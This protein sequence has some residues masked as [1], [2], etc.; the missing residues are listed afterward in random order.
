MTEELDKDDSCPDCGEK[1][2]DPVVLKNAGGL[3]GWMCLN[4]ETFFP[5]K[6]LDIGGRFHQRLS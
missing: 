1:P 3:V 4:C 2:L 6:N 5:I